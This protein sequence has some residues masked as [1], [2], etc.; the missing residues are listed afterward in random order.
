MAKKTKTEVTTK[1]PTRQMWRRSVVVLVILVGVCFSTLIGKLAVLQIVE[2]DEWQ[3]RAV[4]QQMSDSI[5]S[6]KRGAIYDTNMKKLVES[7]DVWTVIMSP[8]DIPDEAARTTIA[9]G[10]SELLGVDRE[11]LY[12]RTGK[13]YS[14]YEVIKSKIERSVMLEVSDWI[15]ENGFSGIIRIIQDY[16][17]YYH[18]GS[19]AAPVLGFTGTDGYG[20]YGLEAKYEDVLGGKP[21]RIVTAKNGW[22]DEMPTTMKYENTVDAEDG[23]SL[24]LTID[25]TIQSYAE[26][27]LEVAV[28]ENGCTNR[29]AAIVMDVDTGAILAMATKG[30]FD[31]NQPFEIADPTIAAAIAELSGDEQSAKLLEERQKQWVNKPI[32]DYYEPGSVFK[33]F[34]ASMAMEEGLVDESSTFD[35]TGGFIP[36]GGS[37]MKC[38]VYP[39]NHGHQTLYEAISHSCNPAFMT[40]GTRVGAHLFF[41]YYTAFGFTEKTGIDMLSES[42][43]TSALYH[44]E[45]GVNGLGPVEIAACSIGQTFKI[46]PIQMITALSAVANGGKLMQP[47]VVRQIIDS[48]GNVKENITPTVKRQV[49][50]ED[51]SDRICALLSDAV[52]EGGGSKNAYVPGYRV[53]GKTGTSDKTDKYNQTGISDV[54]ASFGGFAPSDDPKVAILVLL[55][56]P[57]VS[58]RFGGTIS[59][60]VAQKILA[61]TLPYLGVE[62]KYTEKEQANL[63]RTTPKVV[64]KEVAAAENMINN[65]ELKAVVVGTGTTVIKQVPEA[66]KE[67]PKGGTVVLYTDEAS[68]AKTVPVPN[69]KG[70]TVSQANAAAANAGLNIQ[71]AGIGLSTGEATATTQSVEYGAQV[72]KGTVITVDFVYEVVDDHIGG[73]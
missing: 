28:K 50:S 11:K 71:L 34:T 36:Q 7:S 61:D 60:P 42:P 13:T 3:K 33:V 59:A 29:G 22:G 48:E 54:V 49:I 65:S 20:L 2:T 66:G 69:F 10:L 32:A 37:L 40:I 4:S 18:Y 21:G 51:T 25:A 5:I 47:Y 63:S 15:T 43:I 45:S 19:L 46:P 27:Y 53:A 38:H 57:Q 8:S 56:E 72:P 64:D 35:C 12:E 1:S 26:K 14:Q 67:I 41:K 24:V 58:V 62:P 44:P 73:E 52:N 23:D 70:M 6:A 39:R 55:D 17:R 30:D 68:T 31:P 9:D 16:K